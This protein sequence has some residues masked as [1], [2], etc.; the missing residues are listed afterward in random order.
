MITLADSFSLEVETEYV[1]ELSVPTQHRYFFTYNITLTNPLGQPVSLTAIKLLLTSSDG[2]VIELNNPFGDENNVIQS[3]DYFCY[4]N[5]I[6]TASPLSIVQGQIELKLNASESIIINI[7]PFRLST[8][9]L[10]H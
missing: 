1:E 2:E 10:L 6:I 7:D 8:P 9:N 5:D 3:Q 4:G